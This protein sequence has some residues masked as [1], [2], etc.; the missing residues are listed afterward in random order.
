MS[1]KKR[2]EKVDGEKYHRVR[3]RRRMGKI[4]DRSEDRGKS[5]TKR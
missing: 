2:R 3:G 1:E 5:Y 4:E